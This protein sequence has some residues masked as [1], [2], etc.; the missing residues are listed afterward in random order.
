MFWNP[1]RRIK[2]L[3]FEIEMR[4]HRIENL[5]NEI[6]ELKSPTTKHNPDAFCIGCEHLVI[7]ERRYPGSI[8]YNDYSC[9]LDNHCPDMKQ[10]ER[11][12]GDGNVR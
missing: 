8:S 11:V 9:K 7:E 1:F 3:E 6:E 10:R 2:D 4:D 5:K 12:G